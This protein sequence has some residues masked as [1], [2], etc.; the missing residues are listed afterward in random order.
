MLSGGPGGLIQGIQ[1]KTDLSDQT[2]ISTGK[3]KSIFWLEPGG[4]FLWLLSKKTAIGN[5]P[6]AQF[7]SVFC[8]K[9]LTDI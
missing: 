4:Q 3:K 7:L 1:L 6:L 9:E 5:V 2:C 8:D